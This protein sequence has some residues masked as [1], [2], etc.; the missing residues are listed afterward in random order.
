MRRL[1]IIFSEV[2]ARGVGVGRS[3]LLGEGSKGVTRGRRAGLLLLCISGASCTDTVTLLP[4]EPAASASAAAVPGPSGQFEWLTQFGSG[5][6]DFGWEVRADELGTVYGSGGVFGALLGQEHHGGIDAFVRKYDT[7]G[8]DLWTRQFGADLYDHAYSVLPFGAAVYV[9]GPTRSGL[10]LESNLGVGDAFLGK[11]DAATGVILWGRQ[12]GTEGP[13][14]L[15]HLFVDNTGVYA[16]GSVTGALPGKT[17]MGG[18][19]A[20]LRKYDS[21]GNE[22]WTHQFGTAVRDVAFGVSGDASGL[23]VAGGVGGPLPGQTHAGVQDAFVRKYDPS[24]NEI[25][26]VQF[27]TAAIDFALNVAADPTGLYAVGRTDGALPGQSHA[28]GPDAYV[29]RFDRGSADLLWVRQFGTPAFDVARG[30]SIRDGL[31]YVSGVTQGALPGQ[32]H[33]GGADVFVRAYSADGD[34]LWTWQFGSELDDDNWTNS[35][36][37]SG[38]YITGTTGGSLL[39]SVSL[40]GSDVFIGRIGPTRAGCMMRGWE[41]FGFRNQGECI[42]YVETGKEP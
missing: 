8:R 34:E 9:G 12:F 42:R 5:L 6:N 39:G 20:F 4:G 35:A 26:T 19:D 1:M 16:A 36:G 40:G 31:V 7:E 15:V 10:F 25:W 14:E 3:W 30:I 11:L 33:A 21:D 17:H 37:P 29:A 18:V 38:L 27:G 23:Y 22:V 41:A 24:G 2:A 32:V 13:D 28:G